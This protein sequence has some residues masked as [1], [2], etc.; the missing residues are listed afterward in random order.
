MFC[1]KCGA[2]VGDTDRFCP[3]CGTNLFESSSSAATYKTGR[4]R[5]TRP[6]SDVRLPSFLLG[7]ILGLIGLVIALVIYSNGNE[8]EESPTGTVIL[9]CIFGMLFW[10]IVLAVIAVMI[11]GVSLTM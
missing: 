10:F 4:Q 6:V 7:L 5:G 8:F 9:W 11:L 2:R 1:P 3:G